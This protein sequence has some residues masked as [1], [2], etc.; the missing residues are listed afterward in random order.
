[1][2]F[3]DHPG[4]T[5]LETT[6]QAIEALAQDPAVAPSNAELQCR[7]RSLA[8]FVLSLDARVSDL[9]AGRGAD[10]GTPPPP[11]PRRASAQVAPAS[12]VQPDEPG[13]SNPRGNEEPSAPPAPPSPA[14][15]SLSLAEAVL[16]VLRDDGGAWTTGELADHVQRER[17]TRSSVTS[18][19]V[20]VALLSLAKRKL[21]VRERDDAGHFRHRVAE[22]GA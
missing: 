2:R 13:G 1:M 7:I 6:R 4:W 12:T 20:S 19:T 15:S 14:G 10:V 8:R 17:M 3:A 18:S 5:G 11:R 22:G 16:R 21:I 9:E